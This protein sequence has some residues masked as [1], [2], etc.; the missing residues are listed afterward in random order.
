MGPLGVEGMFRR[1]CEITLRVLRAQ[2]ATLMSVLRPFV[3]DPMVTWRSTSARPPARKES[4]ETTNA[5]VRIKMFTKSNESY[6]VSA[7]VASGQYG[8]TEPHGNV[9]IDS[10]LF[11]GDSYIPLCYILFLTTLLQV[12]F[13]PP[14]LHLAII[15]WSTSWSCCFQ[16]HIQYS[17]GNPIFFHSLYMAKPTQSM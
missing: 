13:H 7:F 11:S 16:I 5:L 14:S 10:L 8:I 17:S 9:A 3:Y 2:S 4:V 6:Q 15:S 12:V 1:S